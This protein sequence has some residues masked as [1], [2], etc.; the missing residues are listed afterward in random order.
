MVGYNTG[1]DWLEF[2]GNPDLDPHP[3]SFGRNFYYCD[4]GNCKGPSLIMGLETVLKY[5]GCLGRG[6]YSPIAS[7]EY[8]SALHNVVLLYGW[9]NV[10]ST[11]F[12]F[13]EMSLTRRNPVYATAQ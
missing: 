13:S 10:V 5:A 8:F 2:G 11:N 3:Q 7:S 1:T 6:L 12:I 9:H 4:I